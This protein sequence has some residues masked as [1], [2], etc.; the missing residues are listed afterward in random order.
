MGFEMPRMHDV[1]PLLDVEALT[2][3]LQSTGSGSLYC[4]R[5][6][7]TQ[8]FVS[9]TYEQWFKSLI[10]HVGGIVSFGARSDFCI[11]G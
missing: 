8:I 11:L 3:R 4:P 1:V 6:A 2:A 5:V 10:A 7:L 9:C